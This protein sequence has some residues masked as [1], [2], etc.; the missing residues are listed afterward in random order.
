MGIGPTHIST[1]THG[2]LVHVIVLSGGKEEEKVKEKQRRI[3]RKGRER[4][5]QS[6]QMR[7]QATS[8]GWTDTVR[9]LQS[10]T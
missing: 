8:G 6:T 9:E 2:T 1:L 4:E 3:G 5:G 7:W 10:E